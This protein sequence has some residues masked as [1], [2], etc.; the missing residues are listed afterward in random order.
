MAQYPNMQGLMYDPY[1]PKGKRFT[2]LRRATIMRLY[3]SSACL[4]RTGEVLVSGC[5]TCSQ[6]VIGLV[7]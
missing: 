5:E 2:P 1:A 7:G 6:N 4:T 3:H